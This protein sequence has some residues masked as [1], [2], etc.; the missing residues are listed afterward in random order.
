MFHDQSNLEE[1]SNEPTIPCRN[2]HSKDHAW[3]SIRQPRCAKLSSSQLF[4]SS[5][6]R[7]WI[8]EIKSAST[9]LI[10]KVRI[11]EKLEDAS[12]VSRKHPVEETA[13][14]T[15]SFTRKRII[16]VQPIF[17]GAVSFKV[18]GSDG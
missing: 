3:P 12:I 8:L 13:L 1:H 6:K 11:E 18:H 14:E 17:E 9:S 4:N 15:Q 7:S 16:E 2:Y 10:Q 5:Y